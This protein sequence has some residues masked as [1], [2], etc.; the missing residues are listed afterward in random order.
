MADLRNISPVTLASRKLA[1]TLFGLGLAASHLAGQVQPAAFSENANIDHKSLLFSEIESKQTSL[2]FRNDW[3]APAAFESA[4]TLSFAGGGVAM[5][6][7][8]GDGLTDLYLSR[9]FGGGKLYRNLGGFRFEDVTVAAGLGGPGTR[10]SGRPAVPGQISTTMA[11]ST[12]LSAH[13]KVAIGCI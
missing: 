4:R 13:S 3:Q 6:D 8:D 5:G 2:D 11:T 1:T 9:P 10:N 12:C 7:Y